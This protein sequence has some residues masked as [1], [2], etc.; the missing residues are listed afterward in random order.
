MQK[1]IAEFEMSTPGY[2]GAGVD[3]LE[4]RAASLRGVLRFWWR[5]LMCHKYESDINGLRQAEAS[6]FGSTA[7]QG[8]VHF[9][10]VRGVT[11]PG[12]PGLL[13]DRF[14]G[15]KYLGYGLQ[16]RH[17]WQHSWTFELPMVFRGTDAEELEASLKV[18]GLIG[19]AGARS[20]RG[21]GSLSLLRL[22]RDGEVRWTL[23]PDLEAWKKGWREVMAWARLDGLPETHEYP[24]FTSLGSMTRIHLL[25]TGPDPVRLLDAVGQEFQRYRSYGR[26]GQVLRGPAEKNFPGDHDLML[27]ALNGTRRPD[28]APERTIFGLPHP[29][30][31]SNSRLDGRVTSS[32]QRR[33]SPLFFHVQKL[34]SSYAALAAILPADFSTEDKLR[35]VGRSDSYRV[36]AAIE[37]FYPVIE[38]FITGNRA[39]SGEFRFPSQERLW[40]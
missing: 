37:P 17:G 8:M 35:I 39:D 31:F 13:T 22:Q 29:Y 30:H 38:R 23:P 4:M 14:P 15:L 28:H 24:R 3:Q 26:G 18:L 16:S 27:N 19:G 33:A 25:A 40:P 32:S 20:R 1:L 5:A 7:G 2:V 34:S 6:L 10:P 9:L 21:F 36:S 11:S 12:E